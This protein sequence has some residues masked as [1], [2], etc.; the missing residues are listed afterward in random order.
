MA[1]MLYGNARVT[2]F[3]PDGTIFIGD[4]AE[5]DLWFFPTGYPHS[6]QGLGPDGCEFLL[7]FDEGMFSEY[8]TFLIS[9]W[10]AHTPGYS[11]TARDILFCGRAGERGSTYGELDGQSKSRRQYPVG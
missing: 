5:G 6:I 2:I 11:V 8:N 1:Y 3:Y 9:G 4:V 10:L 7:V